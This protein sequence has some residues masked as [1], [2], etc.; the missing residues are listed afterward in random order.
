MAVHVNPPA[1]LPKGVFTTNGNQI[2]DPNG[3]PVR[4]FGVGWSGGY[5][6][7]AT[8]HNLNIANYQSMMRDMVRLGVNTV[9]IH[10]WDRGVL[11]DTA[12][13]GVNY[14]LNS[15]LQG[16]TYL[17]VCEKVM[18]YADTIGLRIV[19][20]SHLNEGD[21][22]QQGNGLWYDVGGVSN[23]TDGNGLTGTITDA[24]FIQSWTTRANRFK[25]KP[26]LVGYD[27]RNEPLAYPGDNHRPPLILS[28]GG[29]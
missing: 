23:G 2:F 14:S 3:N 17:G 9:R 1:L 11:D 19:F 15:D 22:F 24:L 18:D 21:S 12:M 5:G 6:R 4:L 26:A 20:E 25:N 16:L 10:S 13:F 29:R 28:S 7:Q 27:I 8:L